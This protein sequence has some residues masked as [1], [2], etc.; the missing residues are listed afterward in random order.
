LPITADD[1]NLA[2]DI[3]IPTAVLSSQKSLPIMLETYVSKS[4]VPV[5]GIKAHL[6]LSTCL[7][8]LHFNVLESLFQAI[9]AARPSSSRLFGNC[10]V[11]IQVLIIS[12]I[13]PTVLWPYCLLMLPLS[14]L[15][16][17]EVGQLGKLILGS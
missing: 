6:L 15:I 13:L 2:L 8:L 12:N 9:S 3:R 1:G 11:L 17:L 7:S 16:E 4:H 5:Y 14:S 10:L